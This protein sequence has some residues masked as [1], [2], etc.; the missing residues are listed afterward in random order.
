MYTS[1]ETAENPEEED[2]DVEGKEKQSRRKHKEEGEG[3]REL[4][5]WDCA[6]IMEE[7]QKHSHPL[8]ENQKFLYNVTL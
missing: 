4:D 6:K 7:F 5:Q 2:A 1:Q 8:K 3:R